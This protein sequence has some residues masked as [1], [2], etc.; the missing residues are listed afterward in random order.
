MATISDS[1]VLPPV[2]K[3]VSL[4]APVAG[5][6]GP[7]GAAVPMSCLVGPRPTAGWP[8]CEQSAGLDGSLV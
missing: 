2:S 4:C 8:L 1:Y 3:A 5:E 7:E 6:H